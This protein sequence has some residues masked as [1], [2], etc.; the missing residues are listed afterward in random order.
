MW[1][2]FL[3]LFFVKERERLGWITL[4]LECHSGMARLPWTSFSLINDGIILSAQRRR[5]N[6]QTLS[7]PRQRQSPWALFHTITRAFR[8]FGSA[9]LLWS[10]FHNPIDMFLRI[11]KKKIYTINDIYKL[12]LT[13]RLHMRVT[14]LWFLPFVQTIFSR[15]A[16]HEQAFSVAVS[17]WVVEWLLV[18]VL[19]D[20]YRSWLS[21]IGIHSLVNFLSSSCKS[22][23]HTDTQE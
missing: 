10:Y 5:S 7:L 11:K 20:T 13:K 9:P 16:F 14:P 12:S 17:V 15:V 3:L 19:K 1:V 21:R 22:C 4:L 2:V 18:W 8:G 6:D 23:R